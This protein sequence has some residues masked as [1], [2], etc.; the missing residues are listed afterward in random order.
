M[1]VREALVRFGVPAP[2]V[3]ARGLGSTR[4]IAGNNSSSGRE[5]NRRVEIVISGDPIG[6]MAYWDRT[7]P[8]LHR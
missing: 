1:V 6:A 4:P 2:W 7:Y 5:Q 3:T 8:L